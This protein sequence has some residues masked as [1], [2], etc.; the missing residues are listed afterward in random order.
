MSNATV[1][2]L[3]QA[4]ASGS[5]TAAFLKG[6]FSGEVLTAFEDC[7]I[8]CLDK[9]VVRSISSGQVGTISSYWKSH[10]SGIPYCR[11]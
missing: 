3:G 8:Y 6:I 9:H 5:T 10:Y 4:A 1:S 2:N 11:K 7:T